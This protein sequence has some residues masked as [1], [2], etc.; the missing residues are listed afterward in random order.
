MRPTSIGVFVCVV[1]LSALIVPA[2]AQRA[3][4]DPGLQALALVESAAPV[5]LSCDAR[6]C[7]ARLTS[8]CLEPERNSPQAG[9]RYRLAAGEITLIVHGPNSTERIEAAALTT[10][11]VERSHRAVRL[12][13]PV[14][15]AIRGTAKESFIEVGSRV[16]LLPLV[17]G[18]G[19]ARDAAELALLTGPL[20]ALGAAHVDRAGPEIDAARV[21]NRAI[22]KLPDTGRGGFGTSETLWARSLAG[23]AST[24]G[25]RLAGQAYGTCQRK[26]AAGLYYSLRNCLIQHHDDLTQGLNE[27]YW[28]SRAGS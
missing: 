8:F 27:N 1:I 3:N 26:A 4:A 16:T 17:E 28:Q 25:R 13:V 23:S 14:D 10:F 22:D 21:L 15:P 12:S 2:T 24:E 18:P 5:P 7:T 20:R 19:T 9:E 11:I 6:A